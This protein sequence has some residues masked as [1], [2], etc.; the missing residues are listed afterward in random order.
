MATK[1]YS[2]AY[3]GLSA[4]KKSSMTEA[5]FTAKAKAWNQKKY[6]TTEPTAKAAKFTGGS[7]TKLASEHT[8]SQTKMERREAVPIETS[9]SST[10]SNNR[11]QQAI[12]SANAPASLMSGTKTRRETRQANREQR[13]GDRQTNRDNKEANR[14]R[15]A[16]QKA[17]TQRANKERRQDSRQD[18]GDKRFERKTGINMSG[19]STAGVDWKS[20]LN[21]KQILGS[22]RNKGTYRNPGK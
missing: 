6:G 5:Q 3:A 21:N 7:K 13:Q 4:E 2:Q 11:M 14:I 9:T 15:H 16:G 18:R 22:E 1:S 17:T 12:A 19:S 10:S 20:S 8:A